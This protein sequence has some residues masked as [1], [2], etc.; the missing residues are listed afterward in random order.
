MTTLDTPPDPA[1]IEVAK[2]RLQSRTTLDPETGCWLFNGPRNS[3]GY[4]M[5]NVRP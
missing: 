5:I 3:A 2:H 1:R 4:R